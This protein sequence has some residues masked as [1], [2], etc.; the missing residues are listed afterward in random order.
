VRSGAA[1]AATVLVALVAAAVLRAQQPTPTE[2]PSFHSTS[3][4]LV[5]LPVVVTDKQQRFVSDLTRDHFTV[6]DNGRRQNI[7]LFTNEDAPVSIGVVI[8]TSGSMAHRLPYVEAATVAF[9]RWSNPED[10]I[11]VTA[12]NDSVRDVLPGPPLLASRVEEL[13]AALSTLVPEGQTALYD[14]LLAGFDRLDSGNRA[15]KVLVLISDGGD[16]VSRA[17]IKQVLARAKRSNTAIYTIGLFDEIDPD[18]NPGVL[19]ELATATG[20][21]RFLPSSVGL[22]MQVCDRIAREIRNEYTLAFEPPDRDGRYHAVRVQVEAPDS[23]RFTVRTRPGYFAAGPSPEVDDRERAGH[24]E[25]GG[26]AS[27][28]ESAGKGRHE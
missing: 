13:S 28:G 26:R 10:E 7:A 12:F 20:G 15:R 16:N 9:A 6:Y 18:K 17:T 23:Q 1:V 19:K 25:S 14:A 27:S 22:V 5:V 11:F 24:D 2:A 4:E 8:D 21:A 3:S